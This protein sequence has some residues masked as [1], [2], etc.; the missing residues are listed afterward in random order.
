MSRTSL[1]NFSFIQP[2]LKGGGRALIME[3]L[4]IVERALLANLRAFERYRQ[5]FYT[6]LTVG[7]GSAGSVQAPQRRG[8]F[9]GGTGLDRL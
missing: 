4:T 9:F 3:R 2:L 5:G 6:Q 1:I 7:N 8:G